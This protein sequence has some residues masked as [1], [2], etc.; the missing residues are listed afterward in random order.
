[1]IAAGFFCRRILVPAVFTDEAFVDADKIFH[2]H[3]I[4]RPI[5]TV[6]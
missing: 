1:M 5:A 2:R 4:A 3:L 6:S